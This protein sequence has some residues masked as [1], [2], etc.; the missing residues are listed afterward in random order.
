MATSSKPRPVW[1]A[2]GLRFECR[3]DCSNCCTNHGKYAYVYLE[4]DDAERIAEFLD[5]TLL[6]FKQRHTEIDDG[7]LILRVED[8][9]CPF[10]DDARCSI[11]PVRPVQCRTFPFWSENLRSSRNWNK[12]AEFCPG[13][14]TGSRHTLLQIGRELKSRE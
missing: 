2:D 4:C 3:P 8:P 12:L 6:A 1:Y 7:E 11:Y 13:I 14:D 9:D 5:L 10:L